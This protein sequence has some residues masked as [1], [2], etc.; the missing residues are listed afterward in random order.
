VIDK[1]NIDCDFVLTRS[2]DLATDEAE[3]A[4]IL[5]VFNEIKEHYPDRLDDVQYVPAKQAEAVS[6]KSLIFCAQNL[7]ILSIC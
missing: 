6:F 3:A 1:E 7:S 2:F 5:K 4:R